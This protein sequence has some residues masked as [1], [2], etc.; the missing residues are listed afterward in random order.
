MFNTNVVCERPLRKLRKLVT[1]RAQRIATSNKQ[2]PKV[3]KPLKERSE[4]VGKRRR[5]SSIGRRYTTD[6]RSSEGP[7]GPSLVCYDVHIKK[8]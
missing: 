2:N 8:T 3:D 5:S 4:Y 7:A 6:W 1:K